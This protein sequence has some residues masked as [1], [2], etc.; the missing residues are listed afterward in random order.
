VSGALVSGCPEFKLDEDTLDTV[1]LAERGK[2]LEEVRR[3]V[4]IGESRFLCKGVEECLLVLK[5]RVLGELWTGDLWTGECDVDDGQPTRKCGVAWDGAIGEEGGSGIAVAR[6]RASIGSWTD[7][8][9]LT[10]D[11][12]RGDS[13]DNE[14]SDGTDGTDGSGGSGGFR[15]GSTDSSGS[16]E[17]I[18]S[19]QR[20]VKVSKEILTRAQGLHGVWN[21]TTWPGVEYCSFKSHQLLSLLLGSRVAS[22]GLLNTTSN[23]WHP[24]NPPS[25]Y[26]IGTMTGKRRTVTTSIYVCS[27]LKKKLALP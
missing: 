1:G 5:G 3:V 27:T 23:S 9:G 25:K 2:K 8:D 22:K 4:A 18:L 26:Q 21:P 6:A 14:D 12:P 16:F 13:E 20:K 15:R 11:A 7:G 19:S 10:V 17:P 24:A